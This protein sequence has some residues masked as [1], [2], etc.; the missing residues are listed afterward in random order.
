MIHDAVGEKEI[1]ERVKKKGVYNVKSY[2]LMLLYNSPCG[3]YLE[4][5]LECQKGGVWGLGNG[6]V[7]S[8]ESFSSLI[9]SFSS[10]T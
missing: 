1:D 2:K 7:F 8:G 4:F 5:H 9:L 10:C 6:N 3:K